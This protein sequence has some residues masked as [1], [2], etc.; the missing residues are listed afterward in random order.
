MKQKGTKMRL[1]T[2]SPQMHSRASLCVHASADSSRR[3]VLGGVAAGLALLPAAAATAASKIRIDNHTSS[4]DAMDRFVQA[5]DFDEDI[6]VRRGETQFRTSLDAT[7]ARVAESKKRL[8][9][10]IDDL[11]AERWTASRNEL[12]LQTGYLRFDL[13]VLTDAASDKGKVGSAND[14]LVGNI[15]KLDLA[16]VDKDMDRSVAAYDDM[17]DSLDAFM[18]S[19]G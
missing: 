10:V 4:Q 18:A 7:K 17:I 12:R 5:A 2:A 8:T 11:K 3:Q 14:V 15:E 16:L 1:S 19:V 6:R 13:D 9:S